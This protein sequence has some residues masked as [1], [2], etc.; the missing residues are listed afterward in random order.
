MILITPETEYEDLS[1]DAD[2]I[3]ILTIG[4]STTDDRHANGQSWSTQL[5]KQLLAKGH[6]VRIYNLGKTGSSTGILL[7]RLPNQLELYRPHI[8]MTMMGIND[9]ENLSY[10]FSEPPLK[11]QKLFQIVKERVY[12]RFSCEAE[13]VNAEK[14]SGDELKRWLLLA[15]KEKLPALEKDIRQ[16]T[17]NDKEV[18]FYLANI[19]EAIKGRRFPYDE[20][21]FIHLL[22]RAYQL[23]PR[24]SYNLRMLLGVLTTKENP[25]CLEVAKEILPCGINLDDDFLRWISECHNKMK[26]PLSHDSLS[27][28]G[29]SMMSGTGVTANHYQKLAVLLKEKKISFVAMQYPTLPVENLKRML[30][31]D[32]EITFVGN[33]ENFREASKTYRYDE[34]FRDRFRSTWGHTTD[35][36][37]K[38]IADSA[39]KEVEPLVVKLSRK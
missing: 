24:G 15:G 4:E 27:I 33:Q 14:P 10:D 25:R 12:S 18:A 30:K 2:K 34:I 37:H 26:V 9:R 28:R 3:R 31:G 23:H 21:E 1:G 36:G 29:L 22:D 32:S 39:M 17:T 11:L 5:E 38:I 16:K 6:K 35:L 19:A 7:S 13:S 20:S 8:V